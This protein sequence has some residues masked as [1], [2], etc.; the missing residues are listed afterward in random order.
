MELEAAKMIGAGIAAI[1]LGGAGI[2][3]GQS[4]AI[5]LQAH[6]AIRPLPPASAVRC[7]SALPSPKRRALSAS[8]SPCSFCSAEPTLPSRPAH[9]LSRSPFS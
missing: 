7:S 9:A 4:S 5:T 6:C 1:A 2:G 8:P 3:I